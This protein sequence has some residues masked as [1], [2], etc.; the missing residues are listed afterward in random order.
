MCGVS[1]IESNIKFVEEKIKAAC[2]RVRNLWD[3]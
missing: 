3:I 2:G 1:S